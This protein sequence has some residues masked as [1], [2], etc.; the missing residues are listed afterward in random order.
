MQGFVRSSLLAF[1]LILPLGAFNTVV[2]FDPD[3]VFQLPP[4]VVIGRPILEEQTVRKDGVQVTRIGAQQVRDLNAMDLPSA[5]RRVPGVMISRHNLVGSYGGAE[6]GAFYIRGMGSAR[7]GASVQAMV[8]GVPKFVGVWTHPL[9]DVLSVDHLE[10]ID[11]YKSPQPVRFGNMSF[12]A[13]NLHSKRMLAEG[14]RTELTTMYGAHETYNAVFN[15]GG[16]SGAF[17]YYVGTALKGT[18]G[19]REQAYAGLRNYWGRAGYRFADNWDASL[20]LSA[21]DNTADDPGRADAPLLPRGRFNNDNITANLTLSNSHERT[22]GFLRLYLDDGKMNWQQ[23]D[24]ANQ[25]GFDTNTDYLNRGVRLQQNILISPATELTVGMDY[26]S[27]GGKAVE[28]RPNPANT[29]TMPE[30]Y[31]FSTAGYASLSHSIALK[32]GLS[33]T[34]SAGFRY[35]HHTV[36]ENEVAP[37]AGLVL[38]GDRWQ[39]FGNFS[40]GFSYAGV[41]SLWFYNTTWNYQAPAYQDLDPER[42]KHYE[43]GLKVTPVDGLVLDMSVFHD[44]GENMLRF[45][46]PPPPPPSFGNVG[47]FKNTGAEFSVGW[48]PAGRFSLFG[49]VT[50]MNPTPSD[51]PQ[52]PDYTFSLG[53]N[54]KLIENLRLSVDMQSVGERWTANDRFGSVFGKVDAFTV[55]NTRLDYFLGRLGNTLNRSSLF[56]AIENLTDTDYEFK[57]GY[58]MPGATGYIGLSFTR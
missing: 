30:K 58:P 51:M 39:L 25:E 15:H 55:V 32:T 1:A 42:V 12:G 27:Y 13:V 49:A 54:V 18:D 29:K 36:F 34:P 20:I 45:V 41:Y 5:L 6:G 21:Y 43:V 19:H 3:T 38:A 22:R 50:V 16:R 35:N 53:A 14:T 57:P 52:A 31:F 2:A 7:P 4:V 44:D 23:W 33:L 37:E 24:A 48:S 10:S 40:R 9:M 56:L 26:D 46:A 17:D 8:D 28:V 47:S 11:I